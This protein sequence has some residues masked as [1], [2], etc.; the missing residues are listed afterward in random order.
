MLILTDRESKYAANLKKLIEKRGFENLA[1]TEFDAGLITGNEFNRVLQWLK[2]TDWSH[3]DELI[4]K[5]Q[6][7]INAPEPERKSR[8]EKN[9][10]DAKLMRRLRNVFTRAEFTAL[11]IKEMSYKEA[12]ALCEE[13]E[14]ERLKYGIRF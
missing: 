8:R 11:G 4:Q 7:V 12:L 2:E 10:I 6:E 14:R 9:L 1:K 3:I 13:K 5:D